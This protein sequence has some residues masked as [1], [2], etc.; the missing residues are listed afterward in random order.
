MKTKPL[1]VGAE[2]APII[3]QH[4]RRSAPIATTR[5]R[6]GS[7]FSI[8]NAFLDATMRDLR[9]PDLAVWLVLFRDSKPNGLARTGQADISR[10]A[11]CGERTVRRALRRLEAKGLLRVFRRG[12][13][14]RGPSVY[15]VMPLQHFPTRPG[16]VNVTTIPD[17]I[18]S[19]Q[20]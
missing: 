17:T 1:A 15:R 19:P 18:R 12:G 3:G 13:L 16:P 10:R 20:K 7:R 9:R 4:K 14:R 6:S 5:H 11:G 2:P 8:L